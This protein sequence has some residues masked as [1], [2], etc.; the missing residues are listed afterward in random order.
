[1][2]SADPYIEFQHDIPEEVI[3][4]GKEHLWDWDADYD[5]AEETLAKIYIA[6]KDADATV[7][8]SG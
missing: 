4:A 1:M 8:D 2:F 3:D 7:K 5:D 6:M